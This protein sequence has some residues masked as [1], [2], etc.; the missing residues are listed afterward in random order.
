VV[1]VDGDEAVKDLKVIDGIYEALKKGK[2]IDLK[3]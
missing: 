1:P 2:K 3:L